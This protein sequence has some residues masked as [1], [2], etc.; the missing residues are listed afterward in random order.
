MSPIRVSKST[1]GL[2]HSVQ[3]KEQYQTP[4]AFQENASNESAVS[5]LECSECIWTLHRAAW[6]RGPMK[7]ANSSKTAEPVLKTNSG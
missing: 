2:G 4:V 3:Y 7:E 6:Q 5:D 1:T